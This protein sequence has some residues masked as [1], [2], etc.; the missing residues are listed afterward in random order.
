MPFAPSL[1]PGP[2]PHAA[3]PLHC[4]SVPYTLKRSLVELR[5]AARGRGD[6]WVGGCVGGWA[7]G[8]AGGRADGKYLGQP[9]QGAHCDVHIFE[10]GRPNP[11]ATMHEADRQAGPCARIKGAALSKSS[12]AAPDLE[13][14]LLSA[15]A[16]GVAGGH[17]R[18]QG[19]AT[20]CFSSWGAEA[21]CLGRRSCDACVD[22]WRRANSSRSAEVVTALRVL[23]LFS[24]RHPTRCNTWSMKAWVR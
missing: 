21:Q 1:A 5:P 16:L 6:G 11:M 3:S 4:G 7:G 12:L 22:Q 10:Y 14:A 13:Q 15:E 19:A 24:P 18:G 23:A 2:H 20:E 9:G 8:R 17:L